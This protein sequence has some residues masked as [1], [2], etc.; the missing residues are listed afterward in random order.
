MKSTF[1]NEYFVIFHL[2]NQPMLTIDSSGPK[3]GIFVFQR[4]GFAD[5][6]KWIPPNVLY[7]RVNSLEHFFVRL[8]PI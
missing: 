4:F 3:T 1:G 5:A 6:V 8:L 2:T 7:Q